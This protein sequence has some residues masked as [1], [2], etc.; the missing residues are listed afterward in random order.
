MLPINDVAVKGGQLD[1]AFRA[2]VDYPSI[3]AIEVLCQG[4]CPVDTTAPA[5]PTGLVATPAAGGGVALDWTDDA[6]TDL[7]GYDVYRVGRRTGDRSPS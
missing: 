4:T 1:L 2:S 5:A 7:I 6:E 3:A